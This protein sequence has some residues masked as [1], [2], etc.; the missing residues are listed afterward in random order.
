MPFM[1]FPRMTGL[2]SSLG[3]SFFNYGGYGGEMG[4]N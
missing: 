4:E 3:I 1:P 2:L